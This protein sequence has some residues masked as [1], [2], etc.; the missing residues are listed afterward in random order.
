MYDRF[1]FDQALFD[2]PSSIPIAVASGQTPPP[3]HHAIAIRG[4]VAWI[5]Y[6]SGGGLVARF[7]TSPFVTWSSPYTISSGGSDVASLFIDPD[8]NVHVIYAQGG[9]PTSNTDEPVYYRPIVRTYNGWSLGSQQIIAGGGFVWDADQASRRSPVWAVFPDGRFMAAYLRKQYDF[10][11][12]STIH[13]LFPFSWADASSLLSAAVSVDDETRVALDI[14]SVSVVWAVVETGS[15]YALARATNLET[16]DFEVVD[17]WFGD[18]SDQFAVLVAGREVYSVF[19]R[20]SRP[21]LR[22]F[23]IDDSSVTEQ[24]LDTSDAESISI[25]FSEAEN[26]PVVVWSTQASEIKAR[27][28]GGTTTTVASGGS[29]SNVA[30]PRRF[31]SLVISWT[32]LASD[33]VYSFPISLFAD[34]YY[35]VSDTAVGSDSLF[36]NVIRTSSDSGISSD[37]LRLLVSVEDAGVG[38]DTLPR[39]TVRIQ[40]SGAGAEVSSYPRLRASDS[41]S[42]ISDTVSRIVRISLVDSGT[43]V[44]QYA[45]RL[46]TYDSGNAQEFL[47]D[48]TIFLQDS[49]EGVDFSY[50]KVNI[51]ETSSSVESYLI[52]KAIDEA[53][54]ST[55]NVIFRPILQ[56]SLSAEDT[57]WSSSGNL[58]D[59]G[60]SSDWSALY[61]RVFDQATGYDSFLVSQLITPMRVRLLVAGGKIRLKVES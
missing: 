52:I 51:G 5:V 24:V 9:T 29:P 8:E 21:F 60:M 36:R 22:I 38:Q 57:A 34:Q 19:L 61:V 48:S 35:A 32:D 3:R 50:V 25:G 28:V 7:S 40:D 4:S 17:R 1:T 59:V 20:A 16:M 54:S 11:T 46:Y 23:N 41:S 42:S 56:E 27:R 14:D 47:G 13:S 12:L 18:D 44:E 6:Q 45:V 55:D 37:V 31:S 33:T 58:A 43:G 2:N 26:V 53:G 30:V 49:H 15:S 10:V 39:K